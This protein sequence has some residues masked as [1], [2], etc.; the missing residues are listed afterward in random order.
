MGEKKKSKSNLYGFF[1]RK[2]LQAREQKLNRR[3]PKYFQKSSSVKFSIYC[4]HI[5]H[6]HGLVSLCRF[7][8]RG[9][10]CQIKKKLL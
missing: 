8:K 2:G 3:K 10:P 6:G 1:L 9:I 7:C 4:I 5:P